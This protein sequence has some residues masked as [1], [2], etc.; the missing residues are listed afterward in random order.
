MHTNVCAL[1]VIQVSPDGYMLMPEHVYLLLSE[2][3]RGTPSTVLQKLKLRAARKLRER[4]RVGQLGDFRPRDLNRSLNCRLSGGGNAG[5]VLAGA[6]LR[7]QLFTARG[8]RWRS[9]I[10][11]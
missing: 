2:P 10:I 7:F 1:N 3:P 5:G 4:R 9:C 8:R 11:C 6:F